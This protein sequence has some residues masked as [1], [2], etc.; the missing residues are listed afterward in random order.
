MVSEEIVPEAA[1]RA[2]PGGDRVEASLRERR[3]ELRLQGAHRVEGAA[4]LQLA[5]EGERIAERAAVHRDAV[6]RGLDRQA[7]RVG[8]RR[9]GVRRRVLG[10]VGGERGPQQTIGARTAR[11]EHRLV[12]ALTEEVRAER[13]LSAV[14]REVA[15]EDRGP[16][17]WARRARLER[18]LRGVPHRPAR[19]RARELN[20][21]RVGRPDEQRG[22]RADAVE[23]LVLVQRPCTH[24]QDTETPGRELE[25]HPVSARARPDERLGAVEQLHP[26]VRAARAGSTQQGHLDRAA[27]ADHHVGE[28]GRHL[29]RAP[30]RDRR[31]RG[32]LEQASHVHGDPRLGRA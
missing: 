18:E 20:E 13:P 9:R 10:R 31:A 3:L 1:A 23:G 11:R 15:H 2:R 12:E 25:P 16:P 6:V 22:R 24:V 7:E 26:H 29:D 28:D 4:S 8:E 5:R 14:R 17:T 21:V 27:R 30:D 19:P 32:A